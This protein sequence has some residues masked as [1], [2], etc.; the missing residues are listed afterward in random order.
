VTTPFDVILLLF[1]NDFVTM[2]I[3]TDNVT[4][5]KNPEKWNVKSL[6][7]SST[8]LA[9]LI[10]LESFAILEIGFLLK[11]DINQIN[12]FIFDMLVFSGQFTVYMVRSRKRFWDSRPGKWL[13]MA[14]FGDIVVIT[15]ISWLGIL[16]TAIPLEDVL[17][18]LLVTFV[19]MAL[20][21]LEKNVVFRH[22]GI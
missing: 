1:A 5:S 9:M 20:I 8:S 14:S 12:T 11:L 10:L 16:V 3:A 21:D 13:L 17:L 7:G 4:S 2:S 22:F 15:L 19:S 6:V 18:V